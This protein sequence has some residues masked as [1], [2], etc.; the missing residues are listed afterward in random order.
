MSQNERLVSYLQSG[1]TINAAQA[2]GLFGVKNLRAR[3]NDLRNT[4]VCV[5]TTRTDSGSYAYRLG[6]PSREMVAMAYAA[7]G[8][9]LFR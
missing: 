5:Y 6:S 9:S 7:V 1:Q 3:I 4:G 2:R 8:G